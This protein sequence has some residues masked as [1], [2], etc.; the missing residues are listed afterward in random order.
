[1]K[2]EKCFLLVSPTIEVTLAETQKIS[3]KICAKII[4]R[5]SKILNAFEILLAGRPATYIPICCSL[6]GKDYSAN[7][8]A[9]KLLKKKRPG[10]AHF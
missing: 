8:S 1:M 10:M 4:V 9:V 7:Q 2:F 6:I 5:K 3:P